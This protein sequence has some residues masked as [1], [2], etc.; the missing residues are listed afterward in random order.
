M[1]LILF[2]LCP[3]MAQTLILQSVRKIVW[4]QNSVILLKNARKKEAFSNVVCLG[5]RNILDFKFLICIIHILFPSKRLDK[6]PVIRQTL[7]NLSL[8]NET[9]DT[10]RDCG[11]KLTSD[12]RCNVCT[13]TQFCTIQVSQNKLNW[14]EFSQCF[15]DPDTGKIKQ[16]MKTPYKKGHRVGGSLP[17]NSFVSRDQILVI[18]Y[19]CRDLD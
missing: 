1:D 6:Y 10:R 3:E 11:K 2:L 7:R 4:R 19:N 18:G 13:T 14:I 5:K 12:W 16:M 17:V 15:Q 8:I 9:H